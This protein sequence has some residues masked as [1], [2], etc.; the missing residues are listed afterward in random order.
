MN[1]KPDEIAWLWSILTGKKTII[2][3]IICVVLAFLVTRPVFM[4]PLYESETLVYVPL[5]ILNQQLSQQGIGFANE[6]EVDQYI[7]ILKSSSV[8]DSL[9]NRFGLKG[10]QKK[11]QL[12]NQLESRIKIEKTRYS[13]VS[14]KVRDSNPE[15]AAD[16]ANQMVYLVETIKQQ[17]FY[18]N[19]LEAMRYS[20]SLYEEKLP[21]VTKLENRLD[22]IE[23]DQTPLSLKNNWL[24]N[25]LKNSYNLELQEL[26]S[27]KNQYERA[28]KDFDTPLPKA[29]VI[30][31]AVAAD[32]PVWPKPWFMCL[33][34]AAG[35]LIIIVFIEIIKRDFRKETP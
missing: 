1:K 34:A 26:I 27:R 23:K 22:S 32:K 16:M 20:K 15:K 24:Y 6:H 21:E 29:Y 28:Q 2:G 18:P 3:I 8:A 19:R 12:Y 7:Q 17:L 10:N 31:S 33:L 25:K 9:I 30:S 14:I 4:K 35:Y 13:S 5:T 11:S